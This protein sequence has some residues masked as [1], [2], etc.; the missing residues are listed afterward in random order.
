MGLPIYVQATNQEKIAELYT[1]RNWTT[2]N[3]LPSSAILNV[4]QDKCG[5]LWVLSYNGLLKYDGVKFHQFDKL[6]PDFFEPNNIFS[7]TETS[8][9]TIW[10]GSYG[11]GLV[12]CKNQ[13]LEKISTPDFFVQE[14][15]A[16]N[17]NNIWIG[18]KNAGV[19]QYV[20]DKDSLIKIDF[21]ILSHSS[22]NYI[23]LGFDNWIWIGTENQGI[24]RYK[25]GMVKRFPS[26]GIKDLNQ[27]QHISFLQNPN[28][29]FISTYTGL[30]LLKEGDI[31]QLTELKGFYIDHVEPTTKYGMV[32]STNHGIYSCDEYGKHFKPFHKGNNLRVIS[33]LE[34]KEGNLW[35]GTY[36]NGLFQIIDNQFR[37]FSKDEGL[38]TNTIGSV[39]VL[40]NNAVLAGSIDGKINIIEDSKIKDYPIN[41]TLP[42]AKIYG[43]LQDSKNNLWISTYKGLYQKQASGNVK[44]YDTH[45]GLAGKLCRAIYEDKKGHIWVAT[46][47]SGISILQNNGQ[48][49][50]YNKTNGLSSNFILAIDED[51]AGNMI[52]CTDNSG[53]NIIRP[54]GII[55]HIGTKQGLSNDL[56]FNATIDPDSSYWVAT[57]TGISHITK[58]NII[59]FDQ[60]SGISTDAI[61]DIIPDD[62]GYFWLS[63]NEGVLRVKK[64]ELLAYEKD[65]GSTINW[66]LY[67]KKNGLNTYECAGASHSQI[68]HNGIIWIPALNGLIRINPHKIIK[69][70]D[71]PNVVINSI[72]IDSISYNDHE[73]I[74]LQTG[75]YRLVFDFASLS[76]T[77]PHLIN[78]QVKLEN[79]DENW[80]D[81]G[82]NSNITYTSLPVGKYVFRV[83]ADNGFGVWNETAIKKPIIITPLYYQTWWFYF[84][85]ITFLVILTSF[86]YKLRI[87]QLQKREDDLKLL[88]A[89]RTQELQKNM[90]IL[91]QEITERK[92]IEKELISAKIKADS[93][94]KSKSEFLANMSHEIRT[95]MNGIIG[96]TYFLK[97]TELNTTQEEFTNT[98]HQSANN[99]LI[100]INDI[101]DFSK[102]EAGKI[103]FEDI[104][105]DFA[106]TIQEIS[107]I[108][109]HRIIEK[110]LDFE[111]KVDKQTPTIVFGDPHRLKQIIINLLNNA[112]KFTDKGSIRLKVAP[113]LFDES[114]TRIK[115]EVSDTGIGIDKNEIDKLFKSFSQVDSSTTRVY[116]GTGLGLAIAKNII[117]LMGGKIGVESEKGIG[118]NFWFWIDYKTISKPAYKIP[119]KSKNTI[120]IPKKANSNT[121]TSK[122]KILL[123]EDNLINQK[124]AKMHMERYGFRVETALNGAIALEMFQLKSY[125]LIFMDI[126]MPEMDGLEATQNIRTYEKEHPEKEPIPIIALTANAMK[127]DRETCLAAGMNDYMSKPFIPKELEI[128]LNKYFP[129]MP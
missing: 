108:F 52:I 23:G 58:N 21:N 82:N 100:L 33:T 125:D 50:Y 116:G 76:F 129:N 45:N 53:I 48:W 15:F 124:V 102:I 60:N 84:I 7:I 113:I 99:L 13:E 37:S 8:D 71:P 73:D 74:K 47:A 81:L 122:N 20:V 59:N 95:P 1:A 64:Q 34:D 10:F 106:K 14:L 44:F 12:K 120:K 67:N 29:A 90:D 46:R 25:N 104:R 117:K 35:V 28:R 93:A 54:D 30:F 109:T 65:S 62:L 91:L 40:N 19:Y 5:Y 55:K 31:S 43:L 115:V 121:K 41:T 128:M 101:L 49:K 39:G 68:D 2:D 17:N 24:F 26:K 69:E 87:K 98:I 56:C 57:K 22:I 16:E 42:K 105:F 89:N 86:L 80:L 110:Q 94:N 97:Q 38:W 51:L 66:E 75:K 119:I 126:Q 92:R 61:F 79:Y 107:D 70:K 103:D 123:A 9:S 118:S 77:A 63:S 112:I 111:F 27:I 6:H 78:Y 83:K 3:G 127:G 4:H 18:T 96:M 32:I 72:Q 114:F 85:L 11:N 36:R 88:I